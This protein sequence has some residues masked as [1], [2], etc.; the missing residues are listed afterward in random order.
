MSDEGGIDNRKSARVPIAL[1]IEYRSAGAFLVAYSTNLSKGGIFIETA[2]PLPVGATLTLRLHAPST[3]PCE[4]QGNVAWVRSEA[5]GPGQPAGMGLVIDTASERYGTVVDEI[6]FSFSGI[7]VLLGTGEPAPRAILS[8]YL[9]SILSCQIVDAKYEDTGTIDFTSKPLDLAVIDLDS[10]GPAGVELIATLR[11]QE[12]TSSVPII[13]LGQLER[14][15]LRAHERGADEA[16]TN[17]PLFAEL[18]AA[19][20]R[21]ISKPAVVR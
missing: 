20:L 7:Q 6:A 21:C 4:L 17:P 11:F 10:S 19:V 8:R 9:R 14:D 13:A 18:Q 12:R 16:L 3:K 15:R 2:D 5:T 1:N